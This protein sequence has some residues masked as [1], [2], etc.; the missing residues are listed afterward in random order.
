MLS[1]VRGT[2]SSTKKPSANFRIVLPP[3]P[4]HRRVAWS[5]GGLIHATG[6]ALME[7][8]TYG[9]APANISSFVQC[10]THVTLFRYPFY[11]TLTRALTCNNVTLI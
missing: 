4:P 9:A 7:Y 2:E 3:P 6:Y 10:A 1:S 8:K 11:K 5:A